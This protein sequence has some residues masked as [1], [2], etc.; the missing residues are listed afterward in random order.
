MLQK[1]PHLGP[2]CSSRHKSRGTSESW[3]LPS[4]GWWQ[5]QHHV[6]I[7]GKYYIT[8]T[9][10]FVEVF[11]N[12]Q[13]L[14]FADEAWKGTG[15]VPEKI[16]VEA[17][18]AI[19]SQQR[20]GVGAEFVDQGLRE[21]QRSSKLYVYFVGDNRQTWKWNVPPRSYDMAPT[22]RGIPINCGG[23]SNLRGLFM[24]CY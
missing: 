18:H 7:V 15:E 5:S 10:S 1:I 19:Q 2:Q 11:F 24:L 3:P 23:E 22:N 13:G 16:Y 4:W 14:D 12:L 20:I 9:S 17:H 8:S 21:S 6:S